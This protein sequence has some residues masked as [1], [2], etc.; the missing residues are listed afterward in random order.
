MSKNVI[1][2]LALLTAL[3]G[4]IEEPAG[5]TQGEVDFFDC[6]GD[7]ACFNQ[8]TI[9][10]TPAKLSASMAEGISEELKVWGK[11]G[12]SCK[13]EYSFLEH[14]SPDLDGKSMECL[15]PLGLPFTLDLDLDS[16]CSGELADALAEIGQAASADAELSSELGTA[17]RPMVYWDNNVSKYEVLGVETGGGDKLIKV[18]YPGFEGDPADKRVCHARFTLQYPGKTGQLT[19]DHFF[20]LYDEGFL[21]NYDNNHLQAPL[22]DWCQGKELGFDTSKGYVSMKDLQIVEDRYCVAQYFVSPSD[23]LVSTQVQTFHDNNGLTDVI[24]KTTMGT[25][26][27]KPFYR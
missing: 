1:I 14:P 23:I 7:L 18:T 21:I 17:C 5:Q 26:I 13:I 15:I 3:S 25:V 27:E 19:L 8:R 9:A 20:D 12:S 22:Q 6:Q 2:F 10:C 16:M 11:S 4:C 24:I